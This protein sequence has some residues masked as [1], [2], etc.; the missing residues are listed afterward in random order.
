MRPHVLLLP[1]LA[2]AFSVPTLAQHPGT[3]NPS[4][5]ALRVGART[6]SPLHEQDGAFWTRVPGAYKACFRGPEATLFPQPAPGEEHTPV[7]WTTTRITKG[8]QSLRKSSPE[9]AATSEWRY[10]LRHDG[11]TEAYDV[12]DDGLEQTFVLERPVTGG[13]FVIQGRMATALASQPT[14]THGAIEF[15]RDGV[16]IVRFGAATV[17]DAGGRALP[18]PTR[19]DGELVTLTVPAEWLETARFPV[20]V[21]PLLGPTTLRSGG[22]GGLPISARQIAI[23]SDQ[24]GSLSNSLMIVWTTTTSLS[25]TD[26]FVVVCNPDYSQPVVVYD[27]I[28]AQMTSLPSAAASPT[29]WV[30]AYAKGNVGYRVNHPIGSRAY[31]AGG[32]PYDETTAMLPPASRFG[33][34]AF[35]SWSLDSL[36]V[37]GSV[38]NSEVIVAGFRVAKSASEVAFAIVAQVVGGTGLPEYLDTQY[39]TALADANFM[40]NRVGD[41]TGWLVI[42]NRVGSGSR[43]YR[44]DAQAHVNPA[45]RQ[46]DFAGIFLA[47][48]GIGDTYL[49]LTSALQNPG[50]VRGQRVSWASA[51]GLP[52]FSNLRDTS[53]P[54][55][56]GVNQV[57]VAIDL[58]TRSHWCVVDQSVTNMSAGADLRIERIG[59]DLGRCESQVQTGLTTS[60][61]VRPMDVCYTGAGVGLFSLATALPAESSSGNAKGYRL[62]YPTDASATAYGTSCGG[63]I[64]PFGLPYSGFANFILTANSGSQSPVSGAL[65][66]GAA[67]ASIPLDPIG[68]TNCVQLVA[69][70]VSVPLTPS[71]PGVLLSALALPS[72]FHGDLYA[73]FVYAAPSQ[74]ALGL[75]TSL[76]VMVRVR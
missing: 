65:L 45:R 49:L 18:I 47:M 70:P 75:A 2:T 67:P 72:T 68:M 24:S 16:G 19:Y 28:D 17:V 14:A 48:D 29:R 53:V 6:R 62:T 66:L 71:S 41:A 5:L 57:D 30:I 20:V 50:F 73:Q 43:A 54:W 55:A 40:I 37:S 46:W 4:D 23:A 13:D 31:R 1:L 9:A 52:V 39:P 34:T 58:R 63:P 7:T 59:W 74:N 35:S 38:A 3:T 21:D 11:V 25:D 51:S 56:V 15:T 61:L 69:N 12:R 44:M 33:W 42:A 32:G 8:D 36:A 76:G 10:E 27:D 60:W 64:L 26:L 22:F